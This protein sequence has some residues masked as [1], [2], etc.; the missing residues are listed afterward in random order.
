MN[1]YKYIKQSLRANLKSKMIGWRKSDSIVK[2]E[3]P[4]DIGKARMLGYKD[5]KGFVMVRVRL[6]RGGRKKK[7]IRHNRRSARNTIRKDI[8]ISYKEVA[9]IRAGNRFRNLEVL[10]SYELGKD[11][12]YYF[13]EVILV[14]PQRPEIQNDR[15]INFVCNPKNRKR[16][17]RGLTSSGQKSRGLRN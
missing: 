6:V 10:N 13:I 14:D 8:V 17:L 9:E 16:V 5:K 15:T 11:G 1:A 2:L 4:S 12:M 3:K 7:M